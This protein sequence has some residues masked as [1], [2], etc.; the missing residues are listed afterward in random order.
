[1]NQLASVVPDAF[2]NIRYLL[3][4][5]EAVDPSSVK[6]ILKNGSPQRLLHVYGPTECTTFSTWYLIQSVP[7]GATIPIGR[8]IANTQTYILDRYLQPVPIGVIGEL[9]IGGPGL[10]KGYL[11]RPELTAQR[12]IPNPFSREDQAR[13]YKTGDLV[14]YFPDGNIEFVGRID[15]QVKIRGFRIELE[16]IEAV[17]SQHS[18]IQSATVIVRQD[19][20]SDKRLVAYVV[21]N[22][23]QATTVSDL[24]HFLKQKL[25][26]HMIPA[27]F[28]MLEAL[29]LTNNGKVDRLALPA[30]QEVRQELE[31][32]FVA[33]RNEL[34]RQL[35]GIWE[36]ILTV[37]PISV[38]DN[39][40]DIGGHSLL[41]LKLFAQIEQKF[42]KKLPLA[43]LFTSGTV[44]AV[45]QMLSIQDKMTENQVLAELHEERQDSWLC[46][47][48]IQPH[49]SKPPLFCVHPA[50]GDVLC[51][52]DLA[53]H[54]GADRP[55]YGLQSLGVDGTQPPLTR[56]ED[57]AE[58]YIKEIQTIQPNG[59][60]FLGG[61]S[62]G[63]VIAY[64]M[65]QQLRR[66]GQQ[67]GSIAIL[68]SS[69]RGYTKR[70]PFQKRIFIHINNFCQFGP[71][72]LSKKLASWSKWGKSYITEKYTSFL[73][74]TQPLTETE[75]DILIVNKQAWET[76]TFQPYPGRITLLRTDDRSRDAQE[77]FVGF[78]TD[79]LLGWGNLITSAID[80]HHIPGSHFTLLKEP[81]VRV[82]AEKLKDCL[83]KA[84]RTL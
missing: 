79:P 23:N 12:F 78:Q 27:A 74:R 49:G 21:P 34:E 3:F 38:R 25:S 56:I 26:N 30:P 42:G 64:E 61:F 66:Q 15:R 63:G 22:Q 16:E 9:Y 58:L 57:M 36:E 82:V 47:V 73:G 67:V 53:M 2:K 18:A 32:T 1:M 7:E 70:L 55:F 84:D 10:A 4:G 62:L 37:K 76:Y 71:D 51:Y 40:F 41:A 14:R 77:A 52:R 33:P 39:F 24:R 43:T 5:G 75:N 81:H 72:Y 46:L 8:P 29:P 80:L 50:G 35:T 45:A 44:E 31:A 69:V 60:Y 54:L 13:L 19:T 83:E 20:Q 65:A 17:L 6:A 59:P 48:P 11:K 28:V 68:D